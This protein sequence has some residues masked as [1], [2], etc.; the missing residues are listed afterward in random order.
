[1]ANKKPEQAPAETP[2]VQ[3]VFELLSI[4]V[5]A[6][7]EADSKIQEY[8]QEAATAREAFVTAQSE[9]V[10]A[11]EQAVKSHAD[12]GLISGMIA[13]TKAARKAESSEAV[14]GLFD[15]D[16]NAVEQ[17]DGTPV[18]YSRKVTTVAPSLRPSLGASLDG[19]CVKEIATG[20]ILSDKLTYR[21]DREKAT[22]AA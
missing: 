6:R 13:P 2:V 21:K 1:M 16:G 3:S 12:F 4:W 14:Y 9:A 10:E 15:K 19:Y 20:K 18:T 11:A 8:D 22:D 5:S 7:N 17:E